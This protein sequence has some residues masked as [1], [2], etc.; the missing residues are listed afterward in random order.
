MTN[1]S[2]KVY[3]IFFKFIPSNFFS[4]IK[5]T[6]RH[7]P[8]KSKLLEWYQQELDT[9]QSDFVEG[10]TIFSNSESNVFGTPSTEEQ[11]QCDVFVIMPFE[12]EFKPIYE[13]HI[14]RVV[15]RLE[16]K[17]LRGDESQSTEIVMHK[18]WS[19]MHNA[20]LVIADY[21]KLNVNVFYELGM[22]HTLSKPYIIITQDKDKPFDIRHL[23]IF[24]YEYTTTGTVKLEEYLKSAI[25]KLLL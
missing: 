25:E 8:D 5:L 7:E 13:N 22:A 16:L 4:Q 20:R 15:E 24:Q 11:F 23:D 12:D 14:K 3:S 1:I 21:S 17:I 2:V 10:N 9:F 6:K 18:I 19:Q